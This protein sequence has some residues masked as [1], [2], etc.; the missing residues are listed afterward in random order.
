MTARPKLKP[1][2]HPVTTKAGR[3]DK[4]SRGAISILDAM[5]D[6]NLFG[7]S[8][9]DPN[10]WAAWCVFLAALFGLLMSDD[11]LRLFKEC[12]GRQKPPADGTNEAWLVCGRRGGKSFILALIAV[13]L[14]CLKD[15]RGFLGPGEKATVMVIAGDRRQALVIMRFVMGLLEQ[16][17]MLKQLIESQ[18]LES[19]TLRNRVVIEVHTASFKST[20]GYT[21]VAALLDELAFWPQDDAAQ[22]DEEVIAAI[23]PG[24]STVPGAMLLC[25]SSPHARRGALWTA[26]RK[27]Y[28][29]E[30]SPV[31]V[32]Q[33]ATR[34][35]NPSVP[36]G[37]ID[38]E[39]ERDPDK[40]KAEYLAQ[41]R[42]DVETF[43]NREVVEACI[44]AGIRERLPQPN[45][46]YFAFV[47]LSGGSV[48]SA[49]LAIAHND[50][51]RQ[52][53]VIDCIRERKAPHSPEV[54]VEEFSKI[55][56]AYGVHRVVGD[57]YAAEWPVEQFMRFQIKYEQSAK[58]KS[59]LYTAMLPL[60]NSCRLELLDNERQINQLCSLERSTGRG[61]AD[62]IDHPPNGHDDLINAIAGV[63]VSAVNPHG[64]YDQ[65]Y[66]WV[67]DDD[68][69]EQ[70][71]ARR[72]RV[73]RLMQ[74]I[75][76]HAR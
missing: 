20:R 29:K 40:N 57:R 54:V 13:F 26:Y 44:S 2:P 50:T 38:A 45:T 14:A 32:W 66:R 10:S 42:S 24:M 52:T 71:A 58:R 6:E 69:D 63:A 4:A 65:T 72:W 8:F 18:T 62:I 21:I 49:A 59:D 19:V 23:K 55:I 7:A 31:L 48:D 47:D 39:I 70:E 75:A 67:S 12:T 43:V 15:W 73:S 27:C 9:P 68:G 28:G 64:G 46:Q 11:Q 51:S 1:H 33:A 61:R 17:P 25:A 53:V 76:Q 22:P 37:W 16:S 36:Q 41:F 74:H 35:M 5:K 34:T 3:L 60:I 30:D 56:K